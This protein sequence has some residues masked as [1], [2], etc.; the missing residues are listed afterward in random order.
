MALLSAVS[1]KPSTSSEFELTVCCRKINGKLFIVERSLENLDSTPIKVPN[2]GDSL[3]N[4]QLA[5]FHDG[6]SRWIVYQTADDDG[7][8]SVIRARCRDQEDSK[9]SP[10]A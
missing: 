10:R 3:E 1:R 2:T 6:T 7:N 8:P 4:T 9:S 5:A